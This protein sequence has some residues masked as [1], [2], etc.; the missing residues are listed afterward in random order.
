AAPDLDAEDLVEPGDEVPTL[1][2]LAARVEQLAR[3]LDDVETE[4]HRRPGTSGAASGS[5]SSG[6]ARGPYCPAPPSPSTRPTAPRTSPT[7]ANSSPRRP[8]TWTCGPR[9]GRSRPGWP[10]SPCWTRPPA[11]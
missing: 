6:T 2:E 4:V 3:R 1:A 9:P 5:W 8:G 11:P 10:H 7:P